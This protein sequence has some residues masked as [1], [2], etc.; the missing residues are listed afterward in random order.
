MCK[1]VCPAMHEAA[2]LADAVKG[3]PLTSALLKHKHI[4]MGKEVVG[5]VR[6]SLVVS[7]CRALRCAA[8]D[9]VRRICRGRW[10][11][12]GRPQG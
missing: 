1:P 9:Q 4:F 12:G 11:A 3:G 5:L 10:G 6:R 2:S 7:M 8:C